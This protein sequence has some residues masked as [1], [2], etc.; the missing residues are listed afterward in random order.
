M[1]LHLI[2]PTN[3][4][5]RWM[6]RWLGLNKLICS[7]VIIHLKWFS[8]KETKSL[9]H[10]SETLVAVVFLAAYFGVLADVLADI[11]FFLCTFFFLL[12][13]LRL[14]PTFYGAGS[15]VQQRRHTGYG[16]RLNAATAQ[17]DI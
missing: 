8:W 4:F 12:C 16:S 11:E 14:S 10:L 6:I 7:V 9:K 15:T 13:K 1:L 2:L 3:K 17:L 5:L